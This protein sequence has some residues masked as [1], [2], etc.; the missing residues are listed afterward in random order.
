V[1]KTV[2]SDG[3]QDI[4]HE[5]AYV[6]DGQQVVLKFSRN[7]GQ[8]MTAQDLAARYLYG[9]AVDQVLAEER[10]HYDF[11]QFITDNVLWTLADHEGTIR[12][13]AIHNSANHTT[14][15][16]NHLQ[17]GSFGEITSQNDDDFAP[18][19]FYPGRQY[20]PE[21]DLYYYRA[22]WYDAKTGKF[23]SDDPIGFAA[24]DA[25]LTRYCL[26]SPNN[27]TDPS[28]TVVL[29]VSTTIWWGGG[30]GGGG[31]NARLP[32]DK[33]EIKVYGWTN[34][35]DGVWWY[36][37][38]NGWG[39]NPDYGWFWWDGHRWIGPMTSP[40]APRYNPGRP[41]HQRPQTPRPQGGAGNPSPFDKPP[42]DVPSDL[43]H[44]KPSWFDRQL[45][46][47]FPHHPS[48]PPE[49]LPNPIEPLLPEGTP[50]PP[51]PGGMIPIPP[52]IPGISGKFD[53][54]P[55]PKDDLLFPENH[56]R[57]WGLFWEQRF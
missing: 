42:F 37:T 33:S 41:P 17:Y 52:L 44:P 35:P 20:D 7:D 19:F 16:V 55:F 29:T 24:G 23:L 12:D 36:N 53:P 40:P 13:V 30:S 46:R 10:V 49:G 39:W 18:T 3:D 32:Y 1:G 15:V 31:S 14:T 2:D 26:N 28:G 4:D 22:R 38:G 21:T 27:L 56:E 43:L 50:G 5:E 11:G 45:D 57:K 9:P 48:Q 6:Y 54:P 51:K 47:W 25:N 8:T 34:K